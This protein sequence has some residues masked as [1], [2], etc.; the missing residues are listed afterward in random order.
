MKK[1]ISILENLANNGNSDAERLLGYI[2][3]QSR[4]GVQ[5]KTISFRYNLMAA[6]RDDPDALSCYRVG[7]CY[8]YGDGVEEDETEALNWF[9][10]AYSQ[11]NDRGHFLSPDAFEH[12]EDLLFGDD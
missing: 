11:V 10:K 6:L 8:L 3:G 1:A 12:V 2:Y 7:C 5:D 9:Q 4:Y